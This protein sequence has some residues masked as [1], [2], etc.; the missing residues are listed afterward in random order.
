MPLRV[1]WCSTKKAQVYPRLI[2]CRRT[3]LRHHWSTNFNI[4]NELSASKGELNG[5]SDTT[6]EFMSAQQVIYSEFRSVLCSTSLQQLLFVVPPSIVQHLFN[7]YVAYMFVHMVSICLTSS[8]RLN[9]NFT[10]ISRL[11]TT[12]VGGASHSLTM[13]FNP[14][15]FR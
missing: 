3:S 9:A 14:H 13:V 10:L 15:G 2:Y 12:T 11:T 4:M 7:L 1:L 8:P 5:N 6:V